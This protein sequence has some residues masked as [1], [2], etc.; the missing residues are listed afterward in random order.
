MGSSLGAE[1][2]EALDANIDR[3]NATV[4]QVDYERPF[5]QLRLEMNLTVGHRRLFRT[6]GNLLGVGPDNMEL[7]DEVWVLAGSST[8]FALRQV[9]TKGT[10]YQLLGEVYL[11]GMMHGE[12]TDV[13]TELTEL[14]LV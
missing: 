14:Q 11:H 7:G 3:R 12:A 8:P 13:M 6:N 1:F 5:A 2:E 9:N 10:E 4:T